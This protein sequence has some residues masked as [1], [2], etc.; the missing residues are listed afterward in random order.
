MVAINSTTKEFHINDNQ[1]PWITKEI[2]KL[3]IEKRKAFKSKQTDQ[4]KLIQININKLIPEAGLQYKNKMLSQ[5]P[6]NIKSAWK[7]IKTMSGLNKPKTND[8]N[9]M[10]PAQQQQLADELNTFYTRFSVRDRDDPASHPDDQSASTCSDDTNTYYT[11]DPADEITPEEV[12]D[13]LRR[14]NTG[15]ASGPDN[16]CDKILKYCYFELHHIF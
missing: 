6:T 5:I 1:R 2:K 15:K 12:R 10:S 4:A 13:Q 16:L 11:L 3:L 7:G 14:C 9:L 8:Y